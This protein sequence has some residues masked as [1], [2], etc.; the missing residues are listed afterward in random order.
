VKSKSTLFHFFFLSILSLSITY[1][2]AS[3]KAGNGGGVLYCPEMKTAYLY[4][5]WEG[6][7]RFQW[8]YQE[9]PG[10]SVEG[11]LTRA[12][13][14]LTNVDPTLAGEVRSQIGY[15]MTPDHFRILPEIKLELVPDA[16]ILLVED[17]CG[18][19]QVANWDEEAN[20]VLVKKEY[21]DLMSPM[22]RAALYLHEAIYKVDRNRTQTEYSDLTRKI[23]AKV[24]S[25]ETLSRSDLGRLVNK[26]DIAVRNGP[27]PAIALSYDAQV[28]GY[29]L[30][31]HLGE[32]DTSQFSGPIAHVTIRE[33]GTTSRVEYDLFQ[34]DI[35]RFKGANSKFDF[36]FKLN[37][38]NGTE[39]T[40]TINFSAQPSWGVVI[41][42]SQA[43]VSVP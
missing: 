27:R 6:D 32:F 25:N 12:L 41:Q 9:Q 7:I 16:H 28:R 34:N 31:L 11:Y 38:L 36:T 19:E 20:Q 18:Y 37:D 29:S 42:F 43:P 8:K 3:G 24:M 30:R 35:I 40:K 23:V 13:A 26:N 39:V 14:R 5:L 33:S 15:L 21:F 4:D 2:H 17:G 1:A 22:G 10:L